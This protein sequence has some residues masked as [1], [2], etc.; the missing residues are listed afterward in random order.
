MND[1]GLH[2]RFEV[3]DMGRTADQ[4]FGHVDHDHEAGFVG[5]VDRDLLNII[6]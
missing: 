3:E 5:I 2:G 1:V 4:L 6:N